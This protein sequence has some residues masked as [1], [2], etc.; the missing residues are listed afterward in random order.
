MFT[1]MLRSRP[2][3]NRVLLLA[4]LVAIAI[5]V[6]GGQALITWLNATLL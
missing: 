1:A 3:V 2:L 5:G 6:L 4:T